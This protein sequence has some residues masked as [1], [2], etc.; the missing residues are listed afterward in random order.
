MALE[1]VLEVSPAELRIPC[2]LN[3]ELQVPGFVSLGPVEWASVKFYEDHP[4]PQGLIKPDVCAFPG[5]GIQMINPNGKK[6]YLGEKNGR[7]GNS[8]FQ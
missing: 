4:M 7:R 1:P 2:H 3:R 8:L 6:G 5:P